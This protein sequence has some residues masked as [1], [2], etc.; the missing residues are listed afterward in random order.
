MGSDNRFH[1]RKARTQRE[2]RRQQARREPYDRVLIV[3]EGAKTEPHYFRELRTALGLSNANIEVT[4]EG[5]SA[6]LSVV[7]TAIDLFHQSSDYDHVF[8]V[9]DQDTHATYQAALEKIAV[10]PLHKNG[11]RRAADI[12]RFE[13]IPSVP[14]FEYWILLHYEY[15]TKPYQRVGRGSAC[16]RLIHDLKHHGHLPNYGKGATGLYQQTAPRVND[17][18]QHAKRALAAAESA[19][20][21]N[22]TTHVHELVEVLL[23]LAQKRL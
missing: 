20:T 15:T 7:E 1:K 5:G 10:T 12:A 22:P 11:S 21:D 2:L 16:D 19:S 4:G 18:I 3:C 6:P 9:F 23:G 13:A 14:C 17:A 8:C